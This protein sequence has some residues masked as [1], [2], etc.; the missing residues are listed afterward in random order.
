MTRAGALRD[1]DELIQ[2]VRDPDG[3]EH[4]SE[5]IT[6][7]RGGAVR[8][9]I[10]AT[11]TAVAADLFAKLRTLAMHGEPEAVKQVATLDTN[12]GTDNKTKLLSL[13]RNLLD[14]ALNRYG[15]VSIREH[16]DLKRIQED[17][18]LCAHPAF[19]QPGILYQPSFELARTHIVNAVD[20]V[21]SKAPTLGKSIVQD[22]LAEMTK[23]DFPT[24]AELALPYFRGRLIERSK[25]SAVRAFIRELYLIVL[26]G[27][28]ALGGTAPPVTGRSGEILAACRALRQLDNAQWVQV[29]KQLL[30]DTSYSF[31]DNGFHRLVALLGVEP[32][33]LEWLDAPGKSRFQTWIDN[34]TVGETIESGLYTLLDLEDFGDS[35][36]LRF[37]QLSEADKLE[38]AQETPHPRFKD[39]ALTAFP[40]ASSYAAAERGA[41][42]LLLPYA[43]SLT[44]TELTTLLAASADNRQIY[45]ARDVPGLLLQV[46]EQ[47]ALASAEAL[48]EWAVLVEKLPTWAPATKQLRDQV[49]LPP[50]VPKLKP[51]QPKTDEL[52]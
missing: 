40:K 11:W 21:L 5:A 29:G 32:L 19:A 35:L 17:R 39:F 7:L 9:A 26:N 25:P 4:I 6:A 50:H 16:Q 8:A 30:G 42:K 13:E 10:V 12:I 2:L 49:G 45:E 14:D 1:L 33:A 20:H 36:M 44:P 28:T 22:I 43:S 51:H 41:E 24:K 18:H 27:S 38:V 52:N 34:R 48:Q 47:S 23:P 3:R 31:S 46:F 15:L 37:D